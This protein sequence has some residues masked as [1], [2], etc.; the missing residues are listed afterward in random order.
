MYAIFRTLSQGKKMFGCANSRLSSVIAQ[1]QMCAKFRT[2][3]INRSNR[4]FLLHFHVG[5]FI[6]QQWFP[7]QKIVMD[8]NNEPEP[9]AFYDDENTLEWETAF[10]NPR[11]FPNL[12]KYVMSCRKHNSF[13]FCLIPIFK[14]RVAVNIRWNGSFKTP[15]RALYP[16]FS[17]R[18]IDIS[19]KLLRLCR[20]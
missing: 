6:G 18:I 16:I 7:K 10:F 8:C 17:K 1:K 2:L 9:Y 19:I 5:I 4:I 13:T 15:I 14:V 20:Q 3:P 12:I 11:D